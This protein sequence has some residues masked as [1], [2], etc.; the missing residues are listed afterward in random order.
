MID[1]WRRINQREKWRKW[2]QKKMYWKIHLTSCFVVFQCWNI[3][4][5]VRVNFVV[6]PTQCSGWFVCEWSYPRLFN[7]TPSTSNVFMLL[8][9]NGIWMRHLFYTQFAT[10][11][12]QSLIRTYFFRRTIFR[13]L[14]SSSSSSS[15]MCNFPFNFL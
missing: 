8:V 14:Q 4:I 13:L 1:N 5:F 15:S 11:W 7:F 6:T 9:A 2:K 12:F 10:K 3:A